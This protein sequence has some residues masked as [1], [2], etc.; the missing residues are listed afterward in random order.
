MILFSCSKKSH[1]ELNDIVNTK[2][3]FND[4]INNTSYY[5]SFNKNNDFLSFDPKKNYSVT[6]TYQKSEVNEYQKQQKIFL[7]FNFLKKFYLEKIGTIFCLPLITKIGEAPNNG[8][9]KDYQKELFKFQIL[10]KNKKDDNN[11]IKET[12]IEFTKKQLED[13]NKITNFDV[14]QNE[15][16]IIFIVSIFSKSLSFESIDDLEKQKNDIG[17]KNVNIFLHLKLEKNNN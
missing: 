13:T 8:I 4:V 10:D 6:W 17:T 11:E 9:I 1:D 16:E 15:Y 14:G 2:N 5:F 3:F 7:K 12:V